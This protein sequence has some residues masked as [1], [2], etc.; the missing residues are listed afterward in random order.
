MQKQKRR[1][2]ISTK[3][4]KVVPNINLTK[5]HV[6][7]LGVYPG[8]AVKSTRFNLLN[9]FPIAFLFQFTKVTNCFYLLCMILQTI[10]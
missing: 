10:P 9:F 5:G 1:G 2:S 6:Q 3:P 7:L 4:R 8:N